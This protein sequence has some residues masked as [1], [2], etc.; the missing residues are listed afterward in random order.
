MSL[1][2]HKKPIRLGLCCINSKLREQKP[3][4]FSSR[5]VRLATIES[6]GLDNLKA[7]VILNLLDTITILKENVNL[8]IHVFR[9]TSELFPHS[10]NPKCGGYNIE[11]AS[12]LLKAIGD[13]A[14]DCN[15]R[16]T[17]HPGQF[18]VLC[19]PTESVVVNTVN[20]LNMQARIFDMMGMDQDSVMVIHGGGTYGA[21]E[22]AKQR[23]VDNFE[24][25]S[26]SAQKRL[27][28]ENCE[29]C[30]SVQDC[31]DI[32]YGVYDKY[33]FYVPVVVDSHHVSCYDQ[34]HPDEPNH[35]MSELI[36]VCIQTWVDRGIRMKVHIS[37]QGTGRVGHHSDFVEVIPAYFL[38]IWYIFGERFDIMIEAKAKEQAVLHLM[39]NYPNVL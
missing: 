15:Q 20:E 34:L 10:T 30:F 11:F 17:C 8:G 25:L 32:S 29:K 5:T 4:V 21:K 16:V 1:S 31:I 36:P 18:N 28:L 37:E 12:D 13:T 14:R 22:L 3:P 6:K 23:W 26:K 27:V 2:N 33:G 39:N 38:D 19:S 9:L 24:K 35:N 7:L